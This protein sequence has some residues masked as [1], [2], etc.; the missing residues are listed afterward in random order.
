MSEA[1]IGEIRVFP[2]DYAPSGWAA[3]EGQSLPINQNVALWSVIGEVFGWDRRDNFNLPNFQ[4]R[5]ALQAG[6]GPGIREFQF[7][8]PT[9]SETAFIDSRHLPKHTHSLYTE[10][11]ISETNT[12]TNNILGVL[13]NEDKHGSYAYTKDDV[14]SKK[15]HDQFLAVT[16]EG[17]VHENCQ[18][19][20]VMGYYIAVD[21]TYPA[22]N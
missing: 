6:F 3:C 7:G 21:G 1:F 19:Y 2:Y 12:P 9:G 15:A 18:P 4:G 16:G 20:I 22:P 13:Q 11:E 17:K 10:R 14:P 5:T 8:T